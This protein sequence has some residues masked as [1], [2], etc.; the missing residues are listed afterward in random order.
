MLHYLYGRDLN[1]YPLLCDTMFKDRAK[2]FHGRLKWDVAVDSNGRER[3]QYDDLDP[4][5]VVWELPGGRHGGSARFLP[6][7]GRTMVNEH[8]LHLIDGVSFCSPFIWECT[9]FCLAPDAPARTATAIMLG[10]SELM[11]AFS[12]Q[13][14][15]GV[16]DAAMLRVYRRI[17]ASPDITG[18]HGVGRS[19]ISVGLW[20]YSDEERLMLL[21]RSGISEQ[22]SQNWFLQSV[23][24]QAREP[25]LETV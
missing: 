16:F 11:R 24:R 9:R 3:D 25:I 15:V 18:S 23:D 6:T 1:R 7:T 10:G 5:Y 13:H 19:S 12:V 17:G 20:H 4:L 14:F 8:F 2:Q 21:R 22:Q